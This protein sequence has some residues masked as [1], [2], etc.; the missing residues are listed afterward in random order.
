MESGGIKPSLSL[1]IN[2]QTIYKQMAQKVI[3]TSEEIRELGRVRLP[4]DA[5]LYL[6]M[7]MGLHVGTDKK[8]SM[9]VT[10][11]KMN[12]LLKDLHTPISSV[13]IVSTKHRDYNVWVI[14][15][16]EK[17][18]FVVENFADAAIAIHQIF[19]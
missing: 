9:E 3:I 10:E 2:N 11:K 12:E 8:E 19:K 6:D 4:K 14:H 16:I 15:T 18:N 5:R 13:D 1:V 17:K 7:F